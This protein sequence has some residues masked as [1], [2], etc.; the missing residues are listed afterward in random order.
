MLPRRWCT[1]CLYTGERREGLVRGEDG[2]GGVGCTYDLVV[3]EEEELLEVVI[4][5]T[6]AYPRTVMVHL[7][8]TNLTDRTEM[9]SHGFPI[10]RFF[11]VS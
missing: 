2:G 3:A 1:L 8:N 9:S 7:W 5:S 10:L 4:S 6:I 11:T